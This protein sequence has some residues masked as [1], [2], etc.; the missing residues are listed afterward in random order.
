MK[1]FNTLIDYKYGKILFN[2][3][4]IYIGKSLFVYGEYSEAEIDFFKKVLVPGNTAIEIGTNIGSHTVALSK[5]VGNKGKVLAFE[6]QQVIF[7]TL[8]SNIA[9]NNI[10]NTL[11]FPVALGEKNQDI[12]LP[13]VDY[14]N[15]NNFG[16]ISLKEQKQSNTQIVEQKKL[17]DYIKYVHNVDFIKIDVEGM[18]NSVL[19]GGKK[20]I[21]KFKPVMYIENDRIEKSKELIETLWDY[22]Y[23]LIWHYPKFYNPK[24]FYEVKNNVFGDLTSFNMVCIHKNSDI[25]YDKTKVITDSSKHPFDYKSKK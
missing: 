24:N 15:P 20:L 17:D 18:E 10:Q 14:S 8:C 1:V 12:H 11:T 23:D 3:H 25:K 22:G 7:Q 9:L 2:K 21:Q 13:I 4:D 5:I 6:P 19:K 16:G